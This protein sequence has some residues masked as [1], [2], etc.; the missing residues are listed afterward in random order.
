MRL[1]AV[2][3]TRLRR[4]RQ[5]RPNIW[6]SIILKVTWTFDGSGTPAGGQA[7][8][9]GVEVGAPLLR[10]VCIPLLPSPSVPVRVSRRPR[11]RRPRTHSGG[12]KPAIASRSAHALVSRVRLG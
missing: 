10:T 6:R 4:G 1:R 8:G 12:R 7:L 2:S 3:R 9:D 11:A 5:A